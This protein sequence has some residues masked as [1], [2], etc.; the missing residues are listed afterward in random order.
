MGFDETQMLYNHTVLESLHLSMILPQLNNLK[1]FDWLCA[2]PQWSMIFLHLVFSSAQ[3]S[4][5]ACDTVDTISFRNSNPALV[6]LVRL[7]WH[8]D[9]Y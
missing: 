2:M 4:H 8:I 1:A 3:H 6:A 5:H 7:L 9:R